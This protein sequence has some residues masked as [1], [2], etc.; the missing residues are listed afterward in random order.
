MFLRLKNALNSRDTEAI[1]LDKVRMAAIRNGV[2][3]SCPASIAK[4]ERALPRPSIKIVV[5]GA[6]NSSQIE[7]AVD[8]IIKSINETT[9]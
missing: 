9:L 6:L 2:L 7:K 5:S 8:A 3:I 4:E 1:Y